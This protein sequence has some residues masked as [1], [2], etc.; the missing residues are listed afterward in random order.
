MTIE[1][2][3]EALRFDL[4]MILFDP[5][6]GES[7]SEE[8]FLE[9]NKKC[10]ND[11]NIICYLAKKEAID[12]LDELKA[13]RK[14]LDEKILLNGINNYYFEKG[15]NKAIDDAIEIVKVGGKNDK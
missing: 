2:I 4:D 9:R 7:E 3:Q 13:K 10:N 11:M 15:Y 1:E 6:T 5:Y 8:W 14:M 12:K